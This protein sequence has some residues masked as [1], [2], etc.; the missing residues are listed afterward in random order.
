VKRQSRADGKQ[1]AKVVAIRRPYR[2]VEHR[3]SSSAEELR[4]PRDPRI[5]KET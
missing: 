5:S 2:R 3:I 4:R 1:S